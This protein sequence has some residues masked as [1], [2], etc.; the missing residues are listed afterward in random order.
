[1]ASAGALGGN[2]ISPSPVGRSGE[3][4]PDGAVIDY[5]LP[6]NVRTVSLEILDSTGALVRRFSSDDPRERMLDST[7]IPSY[8]I[9]PE[10]RVETAAGMHRFVWDLHYPYPKNVELSYPISAVPFN[11][12]K[13]PRGPWVLPG[14]YTVRLVADGRAAM[15]APLTVRMDPRITTP[16]TGLVQQFTLSMQL[17]N[18]INRDAKRAAE[19]VPL[20]TMLQETDA[21]PSIQLVA[22]V[23]RLMR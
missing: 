1:L 21:A 23:R 13:E 9:R 15:T 8:W 16:K 11:T 3:N 19:L 18:E 12:V 10:Q 14:R 22:A 4:P 17:Y 20:Y 5:Q 2:A 6:S 7:N